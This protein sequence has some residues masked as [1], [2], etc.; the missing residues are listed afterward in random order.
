MKLVN[1]SLDTPEEN[2]AFDEEMLLSAESGRAEETLRFWE[3]GEYFIV[4][5]RAGKIDQDCFTYKCIKEG[6]KIIRRLSGGGT[7]LQGPG[8]LNYSAIVAYERDHSY[9]DIK[10]SYRDLLSKVASEFKL[11][12]CDI[13][14]FPVSDLALDK[15][16]VSGNAQA[17]KHKF[18]LHH[19]T[20]LYDFDI[21]R[22]SSYLKHPAKE[23]DY[24]DGR[25]HLDFLTNVP[26]SK[27]DIKEAVSKAF[28][29]DE[30]VLELSGDDT[31]KLESLVREKYSQDSWNYAF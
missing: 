19:G 1:L 25:S 29:S 18:F 21:D 7:V 9:R 28:D 16:K 27:E 13:E 30:Y 20:F 22:I 11:K 14:Y 24:R 31:L 3:S 17:R 10:Y 6:I 23:P 8:C 15:K 2:I 5:G 26:L 4:M 12:G